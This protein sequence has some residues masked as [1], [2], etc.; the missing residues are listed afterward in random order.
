MYPTCIHWSGLKRVGSRILCVYNISLSFYGRLRF[1]PLNKLS[2]HE[3]LEKNQA[4]FTNNILLAISKWLETWSCYVSSTGHPIATKFCTWHDTAA[5]V[6]RGNFWSD[7]FDEIEL[8]AKRLF[9][10]IWVR[11]KNRSWN[12]CD[13][14]REQWYHSCI[15]NQFCFIIYENVITRKHSLHYWSFVREIH[16]SLVALLSKGKS[17]GHCCILLT[18]D[19]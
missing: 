3:N 6:I 8:R 4:H 14:H 18:K 19:Q 7:H 5:V 11:R 16:R 12:V 9:Q 17:T 15:L 13:S 2:D 10:W 1:H